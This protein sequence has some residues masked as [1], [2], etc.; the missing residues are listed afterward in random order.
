MHWLQVSVQLGKLHAESLFVRM[1]LACTVCRAIDNFRRAVVVRNWPKNRTF[2][3]SDTRVTCRPTIWSIAISVLLRAH[4]QIRPDYR[5]G[6][7]SES[8][9]DQKET[10]II[11]IILISKWPATDTGPERASRNE[12]LEY[13]TNAINRDRQPSSSSSASVHTPCNRATGIAPVV[14]VVFATSIGS[15]TAW[16]DPSAGLAPMRALSLGYNRDRYAAQSAIIAH[17]Y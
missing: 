6:G 12:T 1:H 7:W 17:T 11:G 8:V 9:V 15:K 14:E 2:R 10:V 3:R 5:Q 16:H 4:T 13:T